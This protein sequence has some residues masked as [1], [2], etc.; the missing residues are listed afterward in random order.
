[1]EFFQTEYEV[2]LQDR[3]RITD[4]ATVAFRHEE[5]FQAGLAWKNSITSHRILPRK[6]KLSF[7][8]YPGADI[9]CQILEFL[10]EQFWASSLRRPRPSGKFSVGVK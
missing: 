5:N 3:P 7:E 2:L 4:I 10:F 6:L 1:V 8:S 9:F